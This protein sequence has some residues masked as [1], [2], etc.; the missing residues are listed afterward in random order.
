MSGLALK[1]SRMVSVIVNTVIHEH[2]IGNLGN[3]V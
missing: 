3:A 2:C 1:N